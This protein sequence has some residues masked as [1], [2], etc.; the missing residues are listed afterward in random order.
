VREQVLSGFLEAVGRAEPVRFT[1]Y[2][3]QRYSERD[4]ISYGSEV[5]FAKAHSRSIDSGDRGRA[6]GRA[7]GGKPGELFSDQRK[8]RGSGCALRRRPPC[9][10]RRPVWRGEESCGS[11]FRPRL[12]VCGR[13]VCSAKAHSRAI[14]S[15]GGGPAF[16]RGCGGKF[17]GALLSVKEGRGAACALRRRPPCLRGAWWRS[18]R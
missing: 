4:G 3:L 6:F 11:G 9:L 8:G 10:R 15:V 18:V 14:D 16:R 7:C 1:I 13:V 5:C 12:V 2:R 17:R